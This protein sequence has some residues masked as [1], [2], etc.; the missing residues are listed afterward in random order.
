MYPS[1]MSHYK[2]D[3]NHG[4][5]LPDNLGDE[6]YQR[7]QE[8]L[9]KK[10]HPVWDM[11]PAE[12]GDGGDHV[13]IRKCEERDPEL[14]RTKSAIIRTAHRRIF[15]AGDT[16]GHIRQGQLIEG[17]IL[18]LLQS[19]AEGGETIQE[20]AEVDFGGEIELIPIEELLLEEEMPEEGSTEIVLV[21]E[22]EP[23]IEECGC[24]EEGE[25]F[26]IWSRIKQAAHRL[27]D[28]VDEAAKNGPPPTPCKG[29][30][31]DERS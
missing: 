28:A 11:R 19:L 22:D 20:E 1:T 16:V 23:V 5:G 9:Q 27:A 24:E 3:R 17:I 15:K 14:L 13:L 7:I 18:Q 26:D 21:M 31:R 8:K 4:Q 29:C 25:G 30:G 6:S 2:R 12:E 10:G